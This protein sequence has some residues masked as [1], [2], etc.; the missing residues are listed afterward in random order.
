[1][2]KD[3]LKLIQANE[4]QTE[5]QIRSI[6]K[7]KKEELGFDIEKALFPINP[8]LMNKPLI[9]VEN[10]VELV[11]KWS[12]VKDSARYSVRYSVMDSVMESEWNSLWNSVCNSVEHSVMGLV[13]ES[14]LHSVKGLVW[15][16]VCNSLG[17]SVGNSLWN[18]LW[19]YISSIFYGIEKWEGIDHEKGINPFQPAI[20]LWEAGYVA[21]YDGE[22][23]RLH[24]G[25]NADVV[26]E[27]SF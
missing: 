9:S 4:T 14:V 25:K 17:N 16:S 22:K 7:E 11:E 27:G 21:S 1:M 10:A 2:N 5:D 26:W 13:M 23:W 18:S 20:D 8:L 15:N 24:C 19:G 6:C 3:L 12:L